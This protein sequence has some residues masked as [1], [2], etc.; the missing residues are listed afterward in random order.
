MQRK[1][2]RN[3]KEG[4]ALKE[5]KL[6]KHKEEKKIKKK[7]DNY[8]KKRWGLKRYRK[9]RRDGDEKKDVVK[10]KSHKQNINPKWRTVWKRKK[11]EMAREKNN[12]MR[13]GKR[14][15]ALEIYWKDLR[16]KKKKVTRNIA[17]D[18]KTTCNKSKRKYMLMMKNMA[19]NKVN[20]EEIKKKQQQSL[21]RKEGRVNETDVA[22][23]YL[24]WREMMIT[25]MKEKG[26]KT[27]SMVL[28]REHEEKI[29]TKKKMACLMTSAYFQRCLIPFARNEIFSRNWLHLLANSILT[30]P[31]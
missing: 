1:C 24:W 27:L 11:G 17:L 5:I 20:E 16:E 15:G 9:R 19:K 3:E 22:E 7:G 8:T 14:F 29:I 31:P 4:R 25:K 23:N 21:M 13:I 12:Q 10:I 28:N 30:K 26:V 6:Q 2:Q 18:K